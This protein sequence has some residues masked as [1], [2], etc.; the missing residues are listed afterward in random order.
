MS[1]NSTEN[2]PDFFS[3]LQRELKEPWQGLQEGWQQNRV[4]FRNFRRKV[5]QQQADYVL[6]ILSGSLPERNGPPRNFWQRRLPLPP[7]PLT[8][9]TVNAVFERMADAGNI[10]GV[11]LLLRDLGAG[12]ATLQ[13][14]RQ[15]IQRLKNAGKDVIVYTPYLDLPNYYVAS[16]AHAIITPPGT[17]FGVLGLRSE[18]LFLK[19]ALA[20][21]GIH[22][23]IIQISPYKS[24]FDQLGKEKMS[25]EFE[26]QI[27]WLLDDQY[28]QLTA[29][30]A[31]G[32]NMSQEQFKALIDSAPY[33][34]QQ[35]QEHGL[36]D[37]VAYEDELATLLQQRL[38]PAPTPTV[39]EAGA[40]PQPVS[41]A[42]SS[43]APQTGGP[44][45]NKERP[46][47][48]VITLGQARQ[49]L[50]EKYRAYH[51][52]RYIGVISLEGNIV[53]GPSRRPPI[54]LPIPFIG[55]DFAG[56]ESI[57][58][59][60]RRAERSKYMAA[61]I[62]L[63]DSGGGSALASDLITRQIEQL[64]KKM[65]VLAYMGNVAASGGYHVSAKCTHIMAQRGT[66][67]GSIGVI[68][69][70]LSNTALL[71][72]LSVNQVTIE[73][74]KRAGLYRSNTPLTE[75]E[76]AVMN[77]GI[78][79]NYHQFKKIVAAGRDIPIEAL[80]PICLGRVWTGQQALGHQLIDSQGDFI[81]AIHKAAELARLP[82]TSQRRVPVVNL[83]R[84]DGGYL[85]PRP[86]EAADDL[87][88]WIAGDWLTN[89]FDG[90]P[91]YLLPF[92]Q[93]LW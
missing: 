26:A 59:L 79:Q 5:Q 70:R 48:K 67:T 71:D 86:F 75:E 89:L 28:D 42:A 63:V 2:I 69:G 77:A 44:E 15:S 32:R 30:M 34:A 40:E 85:L 62:F 18:T 80:D 56:E 10:K 87:V 76:R 19:D 12:L 1:N 7:E 27:N 73:R 57:V 38:N 9:Q 6:M 11:L 90:K 52:D 61:F 64:S 82:Y 58:Q 45:N 21:A 51:P 24:A 65:P 81:D 83:H 53:M 84:R 88:N 31:A 78:Q 68:S 25:P 39:E 54:D 92:S 29:D 43:V 4:A 93:R 14:L 50:L 16:A 72:K 17:E 33:F 23:D 66:I 91:L 49:V 74:G 41:S 35:A 20:H 22:F 60:L 46:T 36:I 55:G 8:M 3:E 37:Y 47:A 13:S